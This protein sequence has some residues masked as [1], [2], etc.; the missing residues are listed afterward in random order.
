[1]II[2]FQH[3]NWCSN[4]C[5]LLF[6]NNKQ[7]HRISIPSYTF[8]VEQRLHLLLSGDDLFECQAKSSMLDQVYM[9]MII[10]HVLVLLHDFEL[11]P[12]RPTLWCLLHRCLFHLYLP[13]Y[14]HTRCSW[15]WLLYYIVSIAIMVHVISIH[16]I[17]ILCLLLFALVVLYILQ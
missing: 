12:T 14:Y 17:S 6:N 13:K 16:V 11:S 4:S 2:L 9:V 8:G 15:W 10:I 3:L 1:M 5:W 7:H